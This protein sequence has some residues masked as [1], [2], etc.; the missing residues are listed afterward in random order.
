M[1]FSF[2]LDPET[3]TRIRRLVSETGWSKSAVVREAVAQYQVDAD[4]PR[5]SATVSTPSAFDR[6]RPYVGAV[7]T[8]GAQL[9]RETHDK[10]TALLRRKHRARRS[11]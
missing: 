4:A 10:Y 1:P 5:G 11:R 9:S 6:L 8:G 3:E 7:D 2:R